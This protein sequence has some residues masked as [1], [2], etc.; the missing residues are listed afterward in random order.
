MND[1]LGLSKR[2]LNMRSKYIYFHQ[3]NYSTYIAMTFNNIGDASGKGICTSL[4]KPVK[5]ELLQSSRPPIYQQQ[6]LR[7]KAL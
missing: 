2:R 1:K 7:Y 4:S 6:T 5:L 3:I